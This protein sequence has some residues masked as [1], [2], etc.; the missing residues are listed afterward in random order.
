LTLQKFSQKTLERFK[1]LIVLI[2]SIENKRT[3][4]AGDVLGS[5]RKLIVLLSLQAYIVQGF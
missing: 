5:F 1:I 3:F 2:E 4:H